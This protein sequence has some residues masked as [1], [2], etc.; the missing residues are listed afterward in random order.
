MKEYLIILIKKSFSGESARV[1]FYFITCLI[2]TFTF[3]L[4]IWRAKTN[5]GSEKQ[6][7]SSVKV[8]QVLCIERKS[9]FVKY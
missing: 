3:C 5:T 2:L 7:Q 1:G 9:Y 8:N 4:K 6:N